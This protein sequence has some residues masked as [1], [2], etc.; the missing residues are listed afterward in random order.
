[1]SLLSTTELFALCLTAIGCRRVYTLPADLSLP[2]L[3]G[4]EVLDIEIVSVANEEAMVIAGDIEAHLTGFSLLIATDGYS[5]S[6]LINGLIAARLRYSPLLVV[7]ISHDPALVN[8]SLLNCHPQPSRLGVMMHSIGLECISVHNLPSCQSFFKAFRAPQFAQQPVVLNFTSSDVLNLRWDL[9]ANLQALVPSPASLSSE[10][11]N[12]KFDEL[13][14]TFPDLILI[15]GNGINRH[16]SKLTGRT[17]TDSIS[18]RF[19]LLPS[20]KGCLN[21]DDPRCIGLFQ[22]DHSNSDVLT[23]FHNASTFLLVEVEDYEFHASFWQPYSKVSNCCLRDEL[24]KKDKT[25]FQLSESN[26]LVLENISFRPIDWLSKLFQRSSVGKFQNLDFPSSSYVPTHDSSIYDQL[27]NLLN[28]QLVPMVL[29]ADVG[30]SCLPLFNWFVRS[31]SVFVS[32]HVWSN[33]GYSFSAGLAAAKIFPNKDLWIVCGDGS[34]VMAMQ[35]MLMF[36]RESLPVKIIILDNHGYLTE[37]LK[38]PGSFNRG[39]D[40]D[41]C[42]FAKSIGYGYAAKV[43]TSESLNTPFEYF[44]HTDAPQSLLSIEIPQQSV[45]NQLKKCMTWDLFRRA[46]SL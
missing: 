26:G 43:Q 21:E 25:V 42:L 27:V 22:G 35:D 32:N 8:R 18:Q 12:E 39:F 46:T 41:W 28:G 11:T 14:T 38:T 16:R 17:L 6:K 3:G 31:E 45:P 34:A 9:K 37:N 30:I 10:S 44:A 4:L 13:L 7:V 2:I 29:I 15:F 33:M 19:L 5:V 1:M 23:A 24:I 20:A 36:V 40:I